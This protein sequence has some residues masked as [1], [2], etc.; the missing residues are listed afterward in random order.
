MRLSPPA[1]E[2]Q[3]LPAIFRKIQGGDIRIPAFQ[4]DFVWSYNQLLSLLE[5]VYRGFPIGSILFWRVDS[6]ILRVESSGETVFPNLPEKFPLSYVLDGLQRLSALYGCFHWQLVDCESPYNVLFDLD[7]EEFVHYRKGTHPDHYLQLSK[8][9]SPKDFLGSQGALS[10][11]PNADH[12][13][14]I[15]VK[16]HSSF[17]EY[18][19]PTV[20]IFERDVEEVVEI[21]ERINSTGTRLDTVDFLRAVTWSEAFDLNDA[22]SVILNSAEDEGFIIPDETAIKIF[23]MSLNKDPTPNAML[24]LRDLPA[25][26]LKGALGLASGSLGKALRFLKQECSI[27]SYDFVP[28]EGQLLLLV[29]Y[30]MSSGPSFNSNVEAM[31]KW[32]LCISFNEGYRGKPDSY[33]VRDMKQVEGF[34]RGDSPPL[35]T[36]LS[37]S[38]EDFLERSFTRGKALSAAV[39]NLFT[40]TDPLSI[41]T[42]ELIQILS[43]MTEFKSN[44]YGFI[45]P[46]QVLKKT[47]LGESLHNNRILANI[48]V[49]NED[50][51]RQ[52]KRDDPVELLSGIHD[53]L[54]NG[55]S[56]LHSQMITRKALD[57]LKAGR[58]DEFLR[59][60][61]LAM[62]EQAKS[63]VA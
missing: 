53:R 19:V 1:P 33:L 40:S 13:L 17:Q 26:E 36:K 7:R 4:R 35:T 62:F 20:T 37:I 59:T 21:F 23:A 16:L 42:G 54:E 6:R 51:S 46:L 43:Y 52:F 39:A 44:N 10:K 24:Q 28:Y 5:S 29:K 31:R 30:A 55:D 57:F 50:E 58:F 14:E 3:Y 15:A 8:I 34:V 12:L 48:L 47:S 2:V 25:K 11:E 63:V 60:R 9:F 45:V 18:L 49:L 32:F 56:I 38:E 27:F 61:A 22:L 41:Y